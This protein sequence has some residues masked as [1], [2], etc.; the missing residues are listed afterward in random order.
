MLLVGKLV[1]IEGTQSPLLVVQ[2]KATTVNGAVHRM[3]PRNP[4]PRVTVGA[5]LPSSRVISS[6]ERPTS[7][8]PS[9]EIYI[10]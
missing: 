8:R 2:D 4:R 3:R 7:Y 9:P 10:N 6:E 5:I 1:R